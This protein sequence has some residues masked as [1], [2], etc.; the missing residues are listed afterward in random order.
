MLEFKFTGSWD[1]GYLTFQYILTYPN[2]KNPGRLIS[3]HAVNSCREY[4]I[5]SLRE[6]INSGDSYIKPGR[7]AYA[8][9][10]FG[11]TY[12]GELAA[13]QELLNVAAEKSL[14]IINSF[15]KHHKWQLT[16]LY[17]VKCENMALSLV[18]FSGP[19]RWT[20]SPYLM[21]I[22]ALMVRLGRNSW[23]PKELLKLNHEDMVK[24]LLA[25]AKSNNNSG[26]GAQLW[27]T[28]R[29][30]DNFMF[31]YK[32]LFGSETRKYHWQLGHLNG[33]SDRPEGIMK[34]MNGTTHYKSLHRRYYKLKEV[35]KLK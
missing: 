28:L 20:M 14:Y 23:L 27:K 13:R 7:R 8:L 33:G 15:E 4:Y 32:D 29:E 2:S 6:K 3:T 31:L 10:S 22:W 17:P 34:L 35:N 24:Q 19:R 26:D 16:K 9:I 12:E 5:K 25:R 18:F 11:R 1:V 21:S 30:W